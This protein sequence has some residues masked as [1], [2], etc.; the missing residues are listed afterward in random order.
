MTAVYVVTAICF[1]LLTL[2]VGYV[3]VNVIVKKRP[4]RIAFLRGFKKGKFAI[5]YFTAIPLF[6]AGHM[7]AGSEFLDAFFD[8]IH[9]VV[10]LVVL[11][12]STSSITLL[13]GANTFFAATVYYCFFLVALN[14]LLFTLSLTGQRLW[15]FAQSLRLAFTS[16]DR[17]YIFGTGGDNE[18][19]YLSDKE[20]V[21]ALVGNFSSAEGD[22]LYCDKVNYIRTREPYKQT[23]KIV[24]AVAK[25]GRGCVVVV[26]TGDEESNIALCREFVRLIDTQDAAV[27][28]GLFGRLSVYVFGDPQYET[29]YYDIMERGHGCIRYVNKYQKVAI[30]FIERYPFTRFMNGEQIDYATSFVKAGVDINVVMMGFGKTNRQIFL[31]SVANNQFLWER[32]SKAELKKVSYHI[33]DKDPAENN[34]N[35]NHSY[36]RYKQ[37][38]DAYDPDR[39]LPLPSLPAQESYHRLDINDVKFYETLHN[40]LCANPRSVNFAVIAFGSD[41]ENID[42]AQKL[43][44]KRKEWEVKNLV[45]FVKTRKSHKGLSVLTEKNCYAIGNEKE[46]VY[47][48]DE[49]IGDSVYRMAKLR[50]EIYDLEWLV[51][52]SKDKKVTEEEVARSREESDRSWHVQRS[53]LERESSLYCCL[54]LR[55]KLNLIGLDYVKKGEGKGRA[56]TEEEYLARYA[57]GDMPDVATYNV[58][59]EG[60]KVVHYDLDFKKSL[61]TNLA[62]HEHQRWNSFM[63]SK[64]MVPADKERILTETVTTPAG[65]VKFSNGKNYS[66]RRHGNLTTFD[67]LVEFRKMVAERDGRSEEETDVIKYDYQLMDDAWWLLDKG[68]YQ[69][70]EKD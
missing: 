50:N 23:E 59:V 41:L 63:I 15:L 60:K 2:E 65:K 53:Q 42:F 7:Y 61:R 49:I 52:S 11:K 45:V 70:V 1:A 48:I 69:M 44:D 17:L 68:G 34:K 46:C 55:S 66:V 38:R 4:D 29:T 3:A 28:E 58:E 56:I 37:E 47:N 12:Y 26:N 30:D 25:K 39:Y 24:D 9:Q 31:T 54:S 57:K 67:G 21:G 18:T 51:T 8:A 14:A 20:R 43:I 10:N 62:I 22:K 27:R 35:L 16:K 13:M 36:Y 64:G 6:C 33:F 32:E 19:L 40:V 5:V